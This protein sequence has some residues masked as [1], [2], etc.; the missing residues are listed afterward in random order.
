MG[1]WFE[2]PDGP[3]LVAAKR[4][5]RVLD[6]SRADGMITGSYRIGYER[7]AFGKREVEIILEDA[8]EISSVRARVSLD[9]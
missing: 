7:R 6:A 2:I 4:V 3:L 1:E 5:L 9:I 8:S